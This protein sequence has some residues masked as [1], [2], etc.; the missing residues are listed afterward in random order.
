M[1]TEITEETDKLLFGSKTY[2]RK[3]SLIFILLQ[4][5]QYCAQNTETT[6]LKRDNISFSYCA[7]K[8]KL[9]KTVGIY[10]LIYWF[11]STKAIEVTLQT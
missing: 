10:N 4:L 11:G 2:S 7:M 9:E 6:K 5:R 3:A 8:A 1:G